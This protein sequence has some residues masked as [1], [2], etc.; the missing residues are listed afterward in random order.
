METGWKQ[1]GSK[2][3]VEVTDADIIS[4]VIKYKF[5]EDGEQKSYDYTDGVSISDECKEIWFEAI[6]GEVLWDREIVPILK[7]GKNGSSPS[8]VNV[9]ILGYSKVS[10]LPLY[11]NEIFEDGKDMFEEE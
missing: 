1:D 11:R 4:N 5:S 10:G 9:D 6:E 2:K 3:P 8:C 7:D